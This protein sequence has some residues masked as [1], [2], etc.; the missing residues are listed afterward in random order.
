MNRLLYEK[1]RKAYLDDPKFTDAEFL[2]D[3]EVGQYVVIL[4]VDIPTTAAFEKVYER[5]KQTAI[6]KKIKKML[7]AKLKEDEI[8]VIKLT[9]EMLNIYNLNANKSNVVEVPEYVTQYYDYIEKT[10]QNRG[11]LRGFPTGYRK[12]DLL[13][14]GL[15]DGDYIILA[16]RPSMGKSA[17]A[18]NIAWNVATNGGV[19]LYVSCEMEAEQLLDRVTARTCKISMRKLRDGFLDDKDWAKYVG[20]MIPLM[21]KSKL[22]I[23]DRQT[24]L[25][26][27][28]TE[29]RRLKAKYG[30]LDLVVVDY[31]QILKTKQRYE[32]KRVMIEEMSQTL[33]RVAVEENTTIIAVSQLS[34]AC[35]LRQD[36][37]PVLADLR[38]TGQLEQDA[39]IVVF[40]YRDE[41]YNPETKDKNIA[42][43]N[44][45]K[46]RNGE[47][48]NLRF[49]WLPEYQLFLEAEG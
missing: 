6:Q 3:K 42:E 8:D 24:T 14:G 22:V 27:T 18:L 12:L 41:Y 32:S 11:K 31:L 46:N 36:K 5:F 25:E 39:D 16:A 20:T 49:T 43:V 2:L 35:E 1:I 4:S 21:K 23:L 17:M 28:I 47:T 7:E 19:V 38:E 13:L 15:Q 10:Y 45:A 29:I 26:N 30:Q 9:Q 34:R 48:A 40:I 33:K 44:I 37:R